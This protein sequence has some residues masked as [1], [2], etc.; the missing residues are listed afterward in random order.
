MKCKEEEGEEYFFIQH[1]LNSWNELWEELS[2]GITKALETVLT[3]SAPA[4]NEYQVLTSVN[5]SYYITVS[6]LTTADHN[7]QSEMDNC[8][9]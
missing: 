8:K 2:A 1:F 9:D 3:T 6:P 7:S 5:L 4:Q